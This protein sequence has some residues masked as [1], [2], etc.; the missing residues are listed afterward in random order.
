MVN[1]FCAEA[2]GARLPD[3]DSSNSVGFQIRE[4]ITAATNAQGMANKVIKPN[5]TFSFG[6]YPGG[7]GDTGFDFSNGGAFSGYTAVADATSLQSNFSAYR[8]VSWGVKIMSTGPALTKSGVIRVI[9]SSEKNFEDGV[10]KNYNGSLFESVVDFPADTEPIYW[11]AKPIGVAARE[12]VGAPGSTAS[13]SFN[14]VIILMN[15]TASV[16]NAL[17]FEIIY[18]IEAIVDLKNA[19]S[20]VA[21]PSEP[22]RPLAI[23]AA[24]HIHSTQPHTHKESSVMS[25]LKNGAISVLSY[26]ANRTVPLLGDMAVGALRRLAGGST[27]MV[28]Y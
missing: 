10:T 15:G 28:P 3:D 5:P 18:N 12:Y 13:C 25:T 14:S 23:Q 24:H 17:T 21:R 11:I 6:S 2:K 27:A 26:L 20:I 4:V 19:L 7:V 9:T 16:T 1:P 8:L 22:H